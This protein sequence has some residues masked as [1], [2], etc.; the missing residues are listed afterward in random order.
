MTQQEFFDRYTFSVRTDK[1]GGG[2]FGN[3]YKAYDNATDRAVAIK[4]AQVQE[5][6][7][8]T[9]SLHDELKAIGDLKDHANIAVYDKVYTFESPQGIF[10]Y[11][12]MMYYP[13]GNLSNYLKKNTGLGFEQRESLCMAILEGIGHLHANK[14]VHRD[15]KPGNILVFIRKNGQVVPKITDFGLSKKASA[16]GKSSRFTNSFAGG[17]LQYS[18]PEQVRGQTLKFNTDLWS[19]GAIAYE[20]LTGKTL[21]Q[22]EGYSSAS[23]EWQNKVSEQILQLD[24]GPL[25]KELPENWAN[26][27]SGCLQRDPIKRVK[28]INEIK[29]LW[30]GTKVHGTK[31]VTAT[32]PEP[33]DGGTIYRPTAQPKVQNLEDAPTGATKKKEKKLGKKFIPWLA[34]AIILPI[35]IWA[36]TQFIGGNDEQPSLQTEPIPYLEN[37]LYG[38]KLGDSTIIAPQYQLAGNFQ[39]GKA[40][41]KV[42]D[43]T[44]YIN[45]KGDWDSS[46]NSIADVTTEDSDDENTPTKAEVE[47]KD[48]ELAKRFNTMAAYQD[49]LDKHPGGAFANEAKNN[50]NRFLAK[51]KDKE[52]KKE[53]PLIKDL[54]EIYKEGEAYYSNK[55][56]DKAYPLLLESAEAGNPRAQNILGSMY[57]Y[58]RGI[59]KDYSEALK[60]FRKA[61]DKGYADAQDWVGIIFYNGEGVE[62][63]YNEAIKWYRKAANQGHANAQKNLGQCYD[64][65]DGISVDWNEARKWYKKASDNGSSTAKRF[66]GEFYVFGVG[67]VEKN[68][69]KAKQLFRE[70]SNIGDKKAQLYLDVI[71]DIEKKRTYSIDASSQNNKIYLTNNGVREFSNLPYVMSKYGA[72]YLFEVGYQLGESKGVRIFPS[73]SAEREGMQTD[74]PDELPYVNRYT[75][76]STLTSKT[77]VHKSGVRIYTDSGQGSR[78]I[79]Y[80]YYRAF[81]N[82]PYERVVMKIPAALCWKPKNEYY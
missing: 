69:A 23:A 65:G 12:V 28:D 73:S 78:S 43:S 18:S 15:L 16:D 66:L 7:G 62:K 53:N 35:G 36:G 79:G 2:S 50:I 10:D 49:F 8:K 46:D 29:G 11:A 75:P 22:V 20:I 21:F 33:D 6:G 47:K 45:E 64:W 44:Y 14:V 30:S 81:F 80:I 52:E 19:F 39:N 38:Y 54:K 67:G 37:G 3:V 70:A 58:G 5:A 41:V 56:Y 61:S 55:E 76:C 42:G 34:A 24:V 57:Y 27:I 68:M 74:Y 31:P 60:W 82:E 71:R 63:N 40:L 48:W 59:K 13:D 77:G 17:T 72:S 25:L 32:Q 4:V 26:V 9:F 1:I 51:E